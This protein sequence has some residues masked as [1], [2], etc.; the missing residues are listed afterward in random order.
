MSS[1][2]RTTRMAA[3]APTEPI[4]DF[5]WA[6]RD[7]KVPAGPPG[8]VLVSDTDPD[9]CPGTTFAV[10]PIQMPSGIE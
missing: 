2:L 8:H 10:T 1:L 6:T 3:G 7:I 5:G 4:S 9:W